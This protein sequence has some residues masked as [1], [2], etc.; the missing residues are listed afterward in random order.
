MRVFS[1]LAVCGACLYAG[2][3][4]RRRLSRR[5]RMISQ[6][7]ALSIRLRARCVQGREPVP[8]VVRALAREKDADALPF[9]ADCV[10]RCCAGAGFPDAWEAAAQTFLCAR[11]TDGEIAALL[12]RLGVLLAGGNADEISAVLDSFTDA[13]TRAFTS[14]QERATTAGKLCVQVGAGAG[15]L[16]GILIL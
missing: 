16:L 3:A 14:A 15:I 11:K 9:L 7:R 5:A 1:A 6:L 8:A 13:C 12:P 2:I 10:R 4:T